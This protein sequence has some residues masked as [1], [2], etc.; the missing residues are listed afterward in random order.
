MNNIHNLIGIG[1]VIIVLL[2]YLLLQSKVLTAQDISYSLLNI[3]GAG[4]ILTSLYYEWNLASVIV[5]IS[6][7]VI[8]A[9]GLYKSYYYG[10]EPD[11]HTSRNS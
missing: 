4:M 11:K 2:T 8:S 7:V 10:T 6:W 5:E 1:G 3:I 9:M